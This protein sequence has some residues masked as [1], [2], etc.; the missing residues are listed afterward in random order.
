MLLQTTTSLAIILILGTVCLQTW[1]QR[2]PNYTSR[3][4]QQLFKISYRYKYNN[5]IIRAITFMPIILNTKT[6]KLSQFWITLAQ[7]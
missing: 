5:F 6:D 2:Y 3:I 1:L 7:L 4:T